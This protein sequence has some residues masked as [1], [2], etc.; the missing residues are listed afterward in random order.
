VAASAATHVAYYT[1][2]GAAYR[3]GD[4]SY[5]YPLMRGLPPMLVALASGVLIGDTLPPLAWAGILLLCGGVLCQ[6]SIRRAPATAALL[7]AG[8]I[9][10]YTI[11][12]GIGV[13]ASGQIFAYSLW[14]FLLGALPLLLWNA[15][16]GS[17]FFLYAVRRAPQALAGGAGTVAAYSLVLWAMTQA[18]VAVVAALRET[19]ILFGAAISGLVLKEKIGWNR[20]AAAL[21]VTMGAILLRLA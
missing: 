3:R 16:Q 12:D 19:A 15:R 10:L 4:M 5:V 2:V 14:I 20:L 9:A 1:L 17:A 8:V 6:V 7:N 11:L 13:R 18:P 21:M